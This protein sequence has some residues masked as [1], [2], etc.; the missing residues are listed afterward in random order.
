MMRNQLT[1]W[2]VLLIPVLL[3]TAYLY[4]N[5]S[6]LAIFTDAW[7]AISSGHA[8]PTVQLSLAEEPVYQTHLKASE[9]FDAEGVRQIY[10]IHLPMDVFKK[11]QTGIEDARLLFDKREI[12]LSKTT[13]PSALLAVSKDE[14][15]YLLAENELKYMMTV[16]W[17]ER[18]QANNIVRCAKL[19]LCKSIAIKSKY[20]GLVEGPFLDTDINPGRRS[21]P[22]GRW[23]L[24]PKTLLNIMSTKPQTVSLQLN[25]LGIQADQTLKIGGAAIRVQKLEVEAESRALGGKSLHPSAYVAVL[26]LK[27]GINQLE[28]A[29]SSWEKPITED[30]NPLAAYLT[31]IILRELE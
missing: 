1:K 7:M 19:E 10:F 21:M 8:A 12:P 17:N 18:L 3:T 29:Y 27:P 6:K 16:I 30:A 20:W 25:L 4:L 31:A 2:L 5:G 14:R 22:K 23:T 26:D 15:V 13:N 28:I 9:I 11:V 24:G